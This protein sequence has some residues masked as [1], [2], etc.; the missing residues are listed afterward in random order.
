MTTALS[1]IFNSYV[2]YGACFFFGH[3]FTYSL[4]RSIP[5]EGHEGG[6]V[7]YGACF[8]FGHHFT[9]SLTRSIPDEGHEEGHEGRGLMEA[10]IIS[11]LN[12]I[13]THVP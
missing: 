6:G 1:L 12:F 13:L 2:R 5:D 10:N 3:H 7:R 8:F 9:Y 11:L 4:T